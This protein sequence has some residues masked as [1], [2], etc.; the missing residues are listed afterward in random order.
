MRSWGRAGVLL[1][2]MSLLL[3]HHVSSL[4]RGIWS[5]SGHSRHWSSP[6]QTSSI[7]E[8]A[9]QPGTVMMQRALGDGGTTKSPPG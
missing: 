5:P 1:Q 4:Q 6:Q 8:H 2:R 9:P 3:A 7:Y